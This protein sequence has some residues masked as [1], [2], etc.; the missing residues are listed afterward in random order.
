MANTEPPLK[1][2]PRIWIGLLIW[3][4]YLALVIAIQA[5]SGIP[6]DAW[7][8]SAGNLFFGAG[9]SLI[10]ATVLLVITTTL[11]G[12]WR[13]ALFERERSRHRW[14]IFV[15]ILTA[16]A[17]IMNLT[18]TDWSAYGGAFLAASL[19]LLLVGFTEELV[20]RGLLLTALRSRLR[21]V[22][23]WLITSVLFGLSHLVNI[24]LGAPDSGTVIQVIS[25]F[26]AGTVFYILLRVTGSLIWAMVLHGLWDFSVFATAVGQA[27]DLA[28]IA[29]VVE[30]TAGFL[31]LACV[32]F[33][34]R[35]ANE[36]T[37][38]PLAPRA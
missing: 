4:A 1:V 27:G 30:L 11:L 32:A 12:W 34:I 38:A 35:G 18:A 16:I 17:A 23:V 33:V 9:V 14:P 13:P 7:G 26:L 37:D 2:R 28:A 22:W 24:L 31:G 10:V 36:R 25:A 15:P 29:N 19:A 20:S 21:E 3:L 6:Y 5:A 8:E